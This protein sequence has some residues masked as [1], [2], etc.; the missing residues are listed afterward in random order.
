[1][2]RN[3][4]IDIISVPKVE[5]TVPRSIKFKMLTSDYTANVESDWTNH[6]EYVNN[7][8]CDTYMK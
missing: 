4:A 2:N 8:L 6:F 3:D 1:M 7:T 5:P